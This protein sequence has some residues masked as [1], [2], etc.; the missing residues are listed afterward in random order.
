MSGTGFSG[1]RAAQHERLV[2]RLVQSLN[3]RGYEAKELPVDGDRPDVR[4]RDRNGRR[5]YIDIKSAYSG[6]QNF[7]IKAGTLHTALA[8]TA[9]G[10][11]VYIV[12]IH[13]ND[14]FVDTAVSF[15][16]R[17][18]HGPR[19]PTGNGSNTDWYL[20]RPGGTPFDEFFPSLVPETSHGAPTDEPPPPAPHDTDSD[21][22]LTFGDPGHQGQLILPTD[23]QAH[24]YAK[25]GTFTPDPAG[26]T[27]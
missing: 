17:I 5:A 25:T 16:A 13:N 3:A 27:S 26:W 14:A 24:D 22:G 21:V 8:I 10:E 20:A 1:R 15:Q 18:K 2:K 12:S 11:P 19:R 4:I 23:Q 7:S 6:H 9:Q